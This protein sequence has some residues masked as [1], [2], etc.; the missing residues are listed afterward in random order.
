[1]HKSAGY[2]CIAFCLS[3]TSVLPSTSILMTKALDR[4]GWMRST[5]VVTRRTLHNVTML[6]GEPTTVATLKMSPYTATQ[7]RSFD[8]IVLSLNIHY[9]RACLEWFTL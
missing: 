3:V 6:A 7:V 9:E 5:A 8:V 2:R 4:S 1:M